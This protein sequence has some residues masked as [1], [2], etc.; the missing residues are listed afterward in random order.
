[1]LATFEQVVPKGAILITVSHGIIH[2][3]FQ[4]VAKIHER[5]AWGRASVYY[6]KHA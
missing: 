3:S 1:M 2:P 5:F 6:Y 4:Q